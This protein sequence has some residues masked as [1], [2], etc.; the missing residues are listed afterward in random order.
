EIPTLDNNWSGQNY[1]GFRNKEMDALLEQI[2]TELDRDKRKKLWHRLQQIYATELPALPLY[3][4]ANSYI[5]PKWLNGLK[6]TGHQFPSTLWVED[7]S[8]NP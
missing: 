8:A 6:P 4:R 3:F 5:M 2:E 1:T 7:W